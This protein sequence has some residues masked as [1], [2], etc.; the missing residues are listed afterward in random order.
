MLLLASARAS[1]QAVVP[2]GDT[3]VEGSGTT[4]AGSIA[5]WELHGEEPRAILVRFSAPP[6]D[7]PDFWLEAK[8]ALRVWEQVSG[9]PLRF[10]VTHDASRADVD[11]VWIDRFPTSQAGSTHRSLDSSGFVEHVTVTLAVAH[12]DGVPMSPEF[13]RLVALHEVGHVVGLPHSENPGDVMHPGNRNL[14]LSPRDIRSVE[15]LYGHTSD[16]AR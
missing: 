16:T 1:G 11:F 7:R 8:R 2:P 6:S 13:V 5:K 3:Y 10:Q 4:D 9:A 14:E 15:I 12:S